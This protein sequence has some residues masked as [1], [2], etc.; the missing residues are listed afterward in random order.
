[1]WLRGCSGCGGFAG[2]SGCCS[3]CVVKPMCKRSAVVATCTTL[4][5]VDVS[6]CVNIFA[7]FYLRGVGACD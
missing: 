6:A 2:F 5:Q 3:A 4:S 1:M 7:V